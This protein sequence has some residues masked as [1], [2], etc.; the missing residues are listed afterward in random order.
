MDKQLTN[1]NIDRQNILNNQYAINEVEKA[2]GIKGILFEGSY[3]FAKQ[4]ISEFY[5]V[6]NRT[7]ERY[8][9]RFKEELTNNGHEV[10][11]AKRLSDCKLAIEKAYVYDIDVV[12]I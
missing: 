9:G 10:L 5:E 6:D 3:R 4:Q 7:I 1:S 12:D 2:V 11:R 8:L